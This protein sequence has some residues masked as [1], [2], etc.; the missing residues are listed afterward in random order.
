[1]APTWSRD[2]K[3]ALYFRSTR[4]REIGDMEDPGRGRQRQNRSPVEGGYYAI[5]SVDGKYLYFT[6]SKISKTL[7]NSSLRR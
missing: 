3:M 5:E 2:A 6:R 4:I 1:M 7:E